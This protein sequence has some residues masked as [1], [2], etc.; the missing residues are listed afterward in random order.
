MKSWPPSVGDG[1]QSCW[2]WVQGDLFWW[3]DSLKNLNLQVV[4]FYFIVALV[5][6]FSSL[7]RPLQGCIPAL[8]SFLVAWSVSV[9]MLAG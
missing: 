9:V 6:S 3:R 4:A 1:F 8:F 2:L 7:Y 5:L